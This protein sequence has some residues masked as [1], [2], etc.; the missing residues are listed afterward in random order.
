MEEYDDEQAINVA[1]ELEAEYA[2]EKH[3]QTF[4]AKDRP[5]VEISTTE[6]TL[7]HAQHPPDSL[8]KTFSRAENSISPTV[9]TLAATETKGITRKSCNDK[10][11]KM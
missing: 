4:R 6:S 8:K 1:L 9:D 11:D 5:S 10:E 2:I 3:L 7:A